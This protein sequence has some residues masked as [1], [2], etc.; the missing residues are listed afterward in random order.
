MPA[1]IYFYQDPCWSDMEIYDAAELYK[2][3]ADCFRAN[4]LYTGRKRLQGYRIYFTHDLHICD[5]VIA[6]GYDTKL[7]K[8]SNKYFNREHREYYVCNNE[9]NDYPDYNIAVV[10]TS[11]DRK[12]ILGCVNIFYC[13]KLLYNYTY[14]Y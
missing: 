11:G 6:D 4:K 12:M 2:E 14:V 9:L 7:C 5:N 8:L 13:H 10:D 3:A 1:K